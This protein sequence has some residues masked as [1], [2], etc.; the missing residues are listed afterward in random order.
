MPE[1]KDIFD[2][3]FM[4]LAEMVYKVDSVERV[5]KSSKRARKKLKLDEINF[6]KELTDEQRVFVANRVKE[7]IETNRLNLEVYYRDDAIQCAEEIMA[8]LSSVFQST[9]EMIF[10]IKMCQLGKLG[11]ALTVLKMHQF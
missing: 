2:G 5:T 3:V 8:K 11:E 4:H 6:N 7:C 10:D 1:K 9:E